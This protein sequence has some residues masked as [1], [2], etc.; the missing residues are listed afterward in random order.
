MFLLQLEVEI[1]TE[2]RL[3]GSHFEIWLP[4]VVKY[5]CFSFNVKNIICRNILKS[6]VVVPHK[7]ICSQ[8]KIL[9]KFYYNFYD[10]LFKYA[11]YLIK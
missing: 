9:F 4:T 1:L 6:L 8:R 11:N 2:V 3:G 5:N 7:R 10:N